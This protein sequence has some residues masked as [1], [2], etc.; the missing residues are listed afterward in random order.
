[1]TLF[2]RA[3]ESRK[4]GSEVQK[5][6]P[7]NN[8]IREI[9]CP[10]YSKGP[11]LP[12]RLWRHGSSAGEKLVVRFVFI[13]AFADE[14]TLTLVPVRRGRCLHHLTSAKSVAFQYRP[15][16][17]GVIVLFL[18]CFVFWAH[19]SQESHATTCSCLF[20]GPVSRVPSGR[21]TRFIP[22]FCCFFV[23]SL[24]EFVV[25]CLIRQSESNYSQYKDFCLVF[26]LS[27]NFFFCFF[28]F[29]SQN[30]AENHTTSHRKK[31]QSIFKNPSFQT[32]FLTHN[33]ESKKQTSLQH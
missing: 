8:K 28:V 10:G 13:V 7:N 12:H 19:V 31:E 18:F 22:V 27:S 15:Q 23:T 2:S 5:R 4:G 16:I 29:H 21:K 1:M 3:G 26:L 20:S 9:E 33:H 30:T 6:G 11:R 32:L 25:K 14:G 17:T 24:R